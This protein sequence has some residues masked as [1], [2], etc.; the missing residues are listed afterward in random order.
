MAK[1]PGGGERIR[2]Q[3]EVL[4]AARHK[5]VVELVGLE[6]SGDRPVLVTALVDGPTLAAPLPLTR[7]EVAGVMGAL[8]TT[9][10]D[11]HEMGIVHGAVV[12]EHVLLGPGGQP[13]L[14]GFG[15]AGPAGDELTPARD[16]A[17]L[18]RLL[19]R[20]ATGPDARA[21]RRVA[22][23]ATADDPDAR[24]SARE[25]AGDIAAA[26]PGAR[27]PVLGKAQ[28]DP[29][30]DLRALVAGARG[31]RRG[32]RPR[33][34][35]DVPRPRSLLLGADPD[36]TA[37]D[38][39]GDGP[40]TVTTDPR[41]PVVRVPS[42]RRRS[43]GPLVA[44]AVAVVAV[45]AVGLVVLAPWSSPPATTAA[46]E[47][48]PPPTTRPAPPTTVVT[49]TTTDPVTKVRADCPEA[50]AVLVADVD[51]DGC[52]DA[53]RYTDGVL[54]AVGLRWA[55]GRAGD[56]VTTGDW[57]CRGVRTVVLLRPATGEVFRFD[58]WAV[59][60]RES[61]TGAAVATVPGGQAVR[62]ADVDRDGCHEVVVE[63]GELPPQV[64]R[65]PRVAT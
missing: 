50:T 35:V 56:Q 37:D 16:V 63:R 45:A 29:A 34:E 51:G 40:P 58:G 25:M 2:R 49:T 14:C 22:E 38:R 46:P 3:A 5:G 18:G 64:V 12:P 62:A 60:A 19:R 26:V 55:L 4:G 41:P 21:L 47:V 27:L 31:G 28:P 52:L 9:L 10:G 30:V 65:M 43:M 32:T 54:E 17:A 42:R 24:P 57:S 1:G 39:R 11:L 20:L 59:G 13:V 61:V 8:A 7:E 53:L 6:G 23:A 33:A 15:S 36:A 44:G 48:A